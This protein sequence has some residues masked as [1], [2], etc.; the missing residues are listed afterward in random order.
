[1]RPPQLA[2]SFTKVAEISGLYVQGAEP[3]PLV[4][5]GDDPSNYRL[6]KAA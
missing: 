2:V 4:I 3:E 5:D 6:K 1:V